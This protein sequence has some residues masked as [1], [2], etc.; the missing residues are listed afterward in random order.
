MY[1]QDG[2][3]TPFI[4][5]RAEI[6]TMAG[7]VGEVEVGVSSG[8]VFGTRLLLLSAFGAAGFAATAFLYVVP[9]RVI[10]VSEGR[11]T[12]ALAELTLAE[13]G[14]RI[15]QDLRDSIGQLMTAVRLKLESLSQRV[16][17]LDCDQ[18]LA[19]AVEHLVDLVDQT[20]EEIRETIHLI[21]ATSPG[22]QELTVVVRALA[23]PFPCSRGTA[24]AI[25]ETP[26][27]QPLSP[28]VEMCGLKGVQEAVAN[29][30]RHGKAR[31]VRARLSEQEGMLRIGVKDDGTSQAE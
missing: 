25:E 13:E 5:Q 23:P 9:K 21:G 19:P 20:T 29:A 12:K 10:A 15:S 22:A 2:G 8:A 6:V 18:E 11:L 16:A 14:R 28:C 4:W 26:I 3:E 27:R 31:K 7:P 24:E 30:F 1:R 17:A